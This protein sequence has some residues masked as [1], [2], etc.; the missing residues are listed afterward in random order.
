MNISRHCLHPKMLR[1]IIGAMV[2]VAATISHAQVV[3]SYFTD[4]P[5]IAKAPGESFSVN[6]YL[7]EEVSAGGVSILSAES[8]LFG[9][10]VTVSLESVGLTSPTQV[11]GVSSS[12]LFA[13]GLNDT[14]FTPTSA[15]IQ[16]SVDFFASAGVPGTSIGDGKR[17]VLLGSLSLVVGSTVGET[18]IFTIGPL[19]TLDGT[20]SF[21]SG[22]QF[23]L[24]S[25]VPAWPAAASTSLSVTA[26][27]EPIH[28]A[29]CVSVLLLSAALLRR[30]R[31]QPAQH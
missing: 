2:A 31:R 11:T 5:V 17:T 24:A 16:E 22:Y 6:L 4:T 23:D 3:F 15:S 18:S 27:P 20:I 30:I 29:L 14:E 25:S 10:G 12:S 8:G 21:T 26:V 1:G 13:G 28:G 9:A 19:P 7:L